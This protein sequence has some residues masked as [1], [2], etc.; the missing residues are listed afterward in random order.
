MQ[1]TLVQFLDWEDPWG[2]DR[3]PTSVFLDFPGGSDGLKCRRP[4]FDP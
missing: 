1:E 3:L 2:R 4:G